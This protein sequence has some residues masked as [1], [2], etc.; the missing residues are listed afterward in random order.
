MN[1]ISI[2]TVVKNGE[3]TIRDCIQSVHSQTVPSEHL[4]IDGCSTDRTLDIVSRMKHSRLKLISEPDQGIYDAMNKGIQFS[5]G[6]IIGILNADDVYKDNRSL[7]L[8]EQVMSAKSFQACYADLVY[9]ASEDMDQVRRFWHSGP[10]RP[11]KMFS[12]WMPPH[13][14]FFVRR[15]LY[16]ACGLFNPVLGSSA[17]YELMLRLIVKHGINPFYIPEVL[18]KMRVGGV[19]NQSFRNRLA[20]HAM[21][22]R[23]WTINGLRPYPWTLLLKPIR[24][25]PQ[26]FVKPP[27]L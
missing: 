22:Y 15:T 5:R 13:P 4:I 16:E 20:A 17:D 2:I 27:E 23:A 19:S 14:T 10:Y 18:V 9:V 6:D 25:I 7:E 11:G 21:D 26:F 8:V 24:K 1:R 3:K 12:G